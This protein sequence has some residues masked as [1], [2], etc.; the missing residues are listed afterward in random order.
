MKMTQEEIAKALDNSLWALR[1]TKD[2]NQKQMVEK[3]LER[4]HYSLLTNT[5]YY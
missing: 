3:E 5:I 2:A 1:E 4:R